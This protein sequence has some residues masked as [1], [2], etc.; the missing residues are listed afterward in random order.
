MFKD[1]KDAGFQL[2]DALPQYRKKNVLVL[3]IPRG[4]VEVGWYLARELEAELDMIICRKLPFPTNPES[5]FGAIAEDG[6][7]CI[8]CEYADPLS[9]ETIAAVKEEQREEIKRRVAVLRGNRPFPDIR[10]RTVILTDDGIAMG[11]TMRA[12]IQ[13]CR[14]RNAGKIVAAAPVAGKFTKRE[15]NDLVDELLVLETPLNFKAVAQVYEKWHDAT[16]DEVLELLK[17]TDSSQQIK[18]RY[19]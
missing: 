17:H 12:A 11:A 10:D 19:E 14:N 13:M 18:D 15:I 4:G 16:D 7:I 2:A 8:L 3:A 9:R 6:S 5:G 1:R